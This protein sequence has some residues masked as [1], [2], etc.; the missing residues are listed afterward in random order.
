MSKKSKMR[1]I[2]ED[3]R[4]SKAIDSMSRDQVRDLL[5]AITKKLGC[6]LVV[7]TVDVKFEKVVDFSRSL[8][9]Q[10]QRFDEVIEGSCR[11]IWTVD[12]LLPRDAVFETLP[13][14]DNIWYCA[15]VSKIGDMSYNFIRCEG[16]G[17]SEEEAYSELI[18]LFVMP[19]GGHVS[20][21]H[22]KLVRF[23]PCS[24]VSQLRMNMAIEE[25]A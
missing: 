25:G 12:I 1:R 24:S 5:I 9:S 8:D 7:R 23:P 16:T 19:N 4:K 11:K 10:K 3:I 22:G 14:I 20:I 6:R 13:V 21:G 18:E 17:L 2:L 15:G